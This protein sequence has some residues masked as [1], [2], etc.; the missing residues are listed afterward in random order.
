MQNPL[1]SLMDSKM[2]SVTEANCVLARLWRFA[3]YDLNIRP[4]R[5]EML[6]R[7]YYDDYAERLGKKQAD[8][9]K[10]NLP[11]A[12]A[13]ESVTFKAFCRGMT[14]LN[15][16]SVE[17]NIYMTREGERKKTGVL[18]PATYEDVGGQYLK[19]LW[20]KILSDWSDVSDPVIWAEHMS[21]YKQRYQKLLNQD[22]S[23]LSSNLSRA[24]HSDSIP[25]NVFYQ[26][27]MVVDF[28]S[29][30]LELKV[31]RASGE[32]QY[33]FNRPNPAMSSYQIRTQGSC[34]HHK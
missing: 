12:L 25:W 21:A 29:M 18:I 22:P 19:V 11:K 15:F 16:K 28:D 5:W 3:L 10:G 7:N 8:N 23:N 31:T 4:S 27:L 9:I 17:F 32:Y 26:G 1:H 34:T 20:K 33:F 30:E 13:H 6:M 2:S 24:L 14:V